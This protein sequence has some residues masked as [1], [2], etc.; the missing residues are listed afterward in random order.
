[1]RNEFT[2][3]VALGQCPV[4]IV[5]LFDTLL[6]SFSVLFFRFEVS[7]CSYGG[8]LEKKSHQVLS[9][10]FKFARISLLLSATICRVHLNYAFGVSSEG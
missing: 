9:S 4:F 2:G 5:F 8:L 7:L 10:Y 3:Q 1:M 6:P